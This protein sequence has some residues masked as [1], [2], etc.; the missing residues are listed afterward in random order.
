MLG[1]TGESSLA[2]H[3]E[4][5]CDFMHQAASTMA[6]Q[7]PSSEISGSL[8]AL[9]R[10]VATIRKQTA[11]SEMAYPHA[12]PN[13]RPGPSG[14]ELPPIRK[15]VELIRAANSEFLSPRTPSFR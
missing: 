10:A 12:R 6:L 7:N 5:A 2:A 3:S 4:F 14:H 8:D 13:Q 1:V 15:T 9:Y 11:A